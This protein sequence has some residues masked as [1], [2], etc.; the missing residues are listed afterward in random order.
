MSRV[1]IT[2]YFL[3]TR[4]EISNERLYDKLNV[5]QVFPGTKPT[6]LS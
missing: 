2:F 6:S 1:Q 5:L 4:F 3:K